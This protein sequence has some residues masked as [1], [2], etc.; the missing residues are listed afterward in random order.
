MTT[1]GQAPGRT[2]RFLGSFGPTAA[3][4]GTGLAACLLLIAAGALVSL[5]WRVHPLLCPPAFVGLLWAA[6]RSLTAL[7]PK[8]RAPR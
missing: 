1:T 6:G 2:D 8:G 3:L 7:T 4:A 5:C